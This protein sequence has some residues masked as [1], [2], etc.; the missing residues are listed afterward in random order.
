MG[1]FSELIKN[2]DKTRDYVRDFFIYGFKVRSEFN[3]KSSRTYDDEKRRAESWLDGFFRYVNTPRGKQAAITLDSGRIYEN[4]LYKA[5]YSKSFTDNDIKLHFMITDILEDFPDGLCVREVTEKLLDR[6][7]EFFDEQTVR[8]KLK[9]YAAEGLYISIRQG[10]KDIFTLS[11]YTPAG[12]FK[13]FPNL[14]NAVKF[15][16]EAS[17]FGVVGNSILRAAEIKNDIFLNKHYYIVHTLEDEIL[18][19]ISEN[20][21]RKHRIKITNFGRRGSGEFQ[22]I[23]LKIYISCRTGRRYLIMYLDDKKRFCSFRLDCI[24]NLLD[25]GECPE[26]DSV[27]NDL[28]NNKD[29]VFGVSFGGSRSSVSRVKI[30]FFADENYEKHIVDRLYREKRSGKV[31][32]TGEN[33]FTYTGEFLDANEI[34]SWLKSFTGRI[35]S[36]SGLGDYSEKIFLSDIKRMKD[37]Y[38]TK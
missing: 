21:S 7:G 17:E 10:K 13:K 14:I 35:V 38:T 37:I 27:A 34:M 19:A 3:R 1:G 18:L 6:Y 31:E 15:F 2:F 11:P 8:N 33:L 36:F 26:F 30:V 32:R 16:S 23:P 20:I 9:E 22:G 25:M 29:K 4:P 24:K 28:A 5:Y 12:L